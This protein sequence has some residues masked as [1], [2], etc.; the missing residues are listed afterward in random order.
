MKNSLSPNLPF[1]KSIT[2]VIRGTD[3]N[4]RLAGSGVFDGGKGNDTI[5]AQGNGSQDT[6]RFNLG[7]GQD[8]IGSYDWQGKQDTVQFGNDV[9][10]DMIGFARSGDNLIVTVGDKDDRMTF[11]HFFADARCQTFTRFEF[12]DGSVWSNI[13]D[14]EAWKNGIYKSSPT[15][16]NEMA[17]QPP[18]FSADILANQA[19]N[20]INLMATFVPQSS[21]ISLQPEQNA[22][23]TAMMLANSAA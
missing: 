17:A 4:D 10:A 18:C 16:G 23:P 13:R 15:S 6:L 7:D 11:D 5:I 8:L 1:T 14:A 12:A 19:N 21:G 20:L 2:P 9:T 3:G 22:A